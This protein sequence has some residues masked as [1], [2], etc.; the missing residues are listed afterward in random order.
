MIWSA[1][2]AASSASS[3][4]GARDPY[5]ARTTL[6]VRRSRWPSTRTSAASTRRRY[7]NRRLTRSATEPEVGGTLREH[8]VRRKDQRPRFASGVVQLPTPPEPADERDP[9]KHQN[10]PDHEPAQDLARGDTAAR[11]G[12]CRSGTD[13]PVV[14]V[15][16]RSL[17]PPCTVGFLPVP[18]WFWSFPPIE[19]FPVDSLHPSDEDEEV[20]YVAITGFDF[21][22]VGSNGS[23]PY[24]S[25]GTSTH[26]W[27]SVVMTPQV[28]SPTRLPGA[29]SSGP[30]EQGCRVNATSRP[31]RWRIADRSRSAVVR[32]QRAPASSMDIELVGHSCTQPCRSGAELDRHHAVERRLIV[33]GPPLGE[34]RY[35]ARDG[36]GE[37]GFVGVLRR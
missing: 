32:I 1:S 34:I 16:R 31:S 33:T 18:L 8:V 36:A 7:S 14:E 10:A 30:R 21:P 15:A 28:L 2:A 37:L 23:Q 25:N 19:Q 20:M 5:A 12:G 22:G 3:S 27:R 9:G 17:S 29:V 26:A 6:P 24:P 13:R 11:C 35:L 4:L